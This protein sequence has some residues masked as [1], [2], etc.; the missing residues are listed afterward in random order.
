MSRTQ[1]WGA[2]TVT[3]MVLVLTGCAPDP[4]PTTPTQAEPTPTPTPTYVQPAIPASDLPL[5]CA[6]LQTLDAVQAQIEAETPAIMVDEVKLPRGAWGRAGMQ[7][8]MLACVWAGEGRT[9]G[10]YNTG[11]TLKVLGDAADAYQAWVDSDDHDYTSWE[12]DRYG[13]AS[14]SY[15]STGTEGSG[16][17]YADCVGDVLVGGY[18]VSYMLRDRDH[19][20]SDAEA[21][22]WADV[23]LQP[24]VAKIETAGEPRP[25]WVP[26]ADTYDGAELCTDA[27]ASAVAGGGI[28]TT[29]EPIE[30][31]YIE[32]EAVRRSG[33]V[34][35]C[36]WSGAVAGL[37][38]IDVSIARGGAWA[39]EGMNANLEEVPGIL[40]SPAQPVSVAGAEAAF[41]ADGEVGWG[42]LVIDGTTIQVFTTTSQEGDDVIPLLE[43]LTADVAG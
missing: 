42:L 41:V 24:V 4:V 35:Q 5:A 26:P 43:L 40:G 23:L 10:G 15:C 39:L 33:A 31:P 18:W 11:L 3:A 13:D 21:D 27:G 30:G 7:G 34:T 9:D 28:T 12:M 36:T 20:M 6:D 1:G 25:R 14:Q 19:P 32:S 16:R 22:A 2:L 8:G 37:N 29:S 38:G 17:T